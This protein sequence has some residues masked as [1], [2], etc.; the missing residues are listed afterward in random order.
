VKGKAAHAGLT[1]S[2]RNAFEGMVGVAQQ[3]LRLKAQVESRKTR[4]AIQPD[5]AR[6]S[7]LLLGGRSGG[8]V[9]FNVVPAECWF[10]VDRRTNPEEDLAAQKRR[11]MQVLARAKRNGVGLDVELLQEGESSATPQD[12]ELSRAL[13]QSIRQVTGRAPKFEM[14]PG[15]LETRF[16]ERKGVPALAYG[17]GLLS[18]SHGPREFVPVKNICDCALVYALTAAKML[19]PRSGRRRGET[20]HA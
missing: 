16:Y 19:G 17:P 4:F 18:V 3:L 14:C 2:G 11:L 5:A 9:N 20:L 10:T 6:R 12:T 8:G 15:L 1:Y 13:T 7:I